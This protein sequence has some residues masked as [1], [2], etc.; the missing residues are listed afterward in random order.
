MMQ[1]ESCMTLRVICVMHQVTLRRETLYFL[2]GRNGQ[3]AVVF[4]CLCNVP[5]DVYLLK[6]LL[7]N[8]P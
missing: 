6:T 8:R 2:D 7:G 4:C 5:F 1:M 3:P